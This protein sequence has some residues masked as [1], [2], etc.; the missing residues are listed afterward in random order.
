MVCEEGGREYKFF[1]LRLKTDQPRQQY[2]GEG[3]YYDKPGH[4]PVSS[5][6]VPS[7]L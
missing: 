2:I 3:D 6:L 7:S 5:L 1:L 4:T